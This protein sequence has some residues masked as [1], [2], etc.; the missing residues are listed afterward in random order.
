M[1]KYENMIITVCE[2]ESWGRWETYRDKEGHN[3]VDV[4]L[5]WTRH[6]KIFTGSID[7]PNVA[8]ASAFLEVDLHY[9]V[10]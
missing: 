6:I 5:K 1:V 2:R 4:V 8:W 7:F 9:L 10:D 3:F